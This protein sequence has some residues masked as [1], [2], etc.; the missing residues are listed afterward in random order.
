MADRSMSL[1]V[2]LRASSAWGVCMNMLNQAIEDGLFEEFR[3]VLNRLFDTGNLFTKLGG[4]EPDRR[5]T[6]SAL[7]LRMAFYPSDSF[8]LLCTAIAT[9]NINRGVIEEVFGHDALQVEDSATEHSS[10][11]GGPLQYG[12]QWHPVADPRVDDALAWAWA[13]TGLS[14]SEKLVLLCLAY[15]APAAGRREFQVSRRDIA[16][17]TGLDRKTVSLARATLKNKGLISYWAPP[18]GAALVTLLDPAGG[19]L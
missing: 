14:S 7:E 2:S 3:E 10:E 5:A 8:L 12:C 11:D 18:G 9:G 6:G 16:E 1:A 13:Q 15:R 17:A 19:V 4:I